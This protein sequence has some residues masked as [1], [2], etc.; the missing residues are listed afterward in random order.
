MSWLQLQSH[1]RTLEL[2]HTFLL[3]NRVLVVVIL[4]FSSYYSCVNR[5]ANYVGNGRLKENTKRGVP[6][7]LIG[8][9]HCGLSSQTLGAPF[10]MVVGH[11]L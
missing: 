11:P 5:F 2:C 4:S 1:N 6:K 9:M 3:K 10:S 8:I 7:I